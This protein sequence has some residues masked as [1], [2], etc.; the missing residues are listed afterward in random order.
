MTATQPLRNWSCFMYRKS[1]D[2]SPVFR[3]TLVCKP[4][5]SRVH[6]CLTLPFSLTPPSSL[7]I[8]V[9]FKPCLHLSYLSLSEHFW[10]PSTPTPNDSVSV[11]TTILPGPLVIDFWFLTLAWHHVYDSGSPCLY[12]HP[13]DFRYW[14]TPVFWL[15]LGHW[16]LYLWTS[17]FC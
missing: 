14:P 2:S 4:L 10:V 11:L 7:D 13:P 5:P 8:P 17:D 1:C 15:I 6:N 16:L 3:S 12:L 9:V